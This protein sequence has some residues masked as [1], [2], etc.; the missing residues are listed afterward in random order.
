[1]L[2]IKIS[3]EEKE[4]GKL[5]V[6]VAMSGTCKTLRVPSIA[7]EMARTI[8]FMLESNCKSNVFHGGFLQASKRMFDDVINKELE[9]VAKERVELEEAE[10]EKKEEEKDKTAS[11]LADL[12]K[13]YGRIMGDIFGDKE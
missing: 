1:M 6:K 10:E 5:N 3:A 2:E 11:E 12:L 4:N 9:K 7:G 8:A 13:D